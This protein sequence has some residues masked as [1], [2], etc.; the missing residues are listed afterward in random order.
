MAEKKLGRV[1]AAIDRKEI[2]TNDTCYICTKP[3][4]DI[5]MTR[6][7]ANSQADPCTVTICDFMHVDGNPS[8]GY[9]FHKHCLDMVRDKNQGRSAVN[10]CLMT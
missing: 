10:Y 5:C 3:L 7:E 4:K 6:C 1:N 2:V 9:A 8:C